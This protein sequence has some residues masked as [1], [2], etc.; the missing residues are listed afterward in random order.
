MHITQEVLECLG[1]E[2][3]VEQGNGK[4]RDYY[5][6][7]NNIKTYLIVDDGDRRPK[8]QYNVQTGSATGQLKCDATCQNQNFF[9]HLT[10]STDPL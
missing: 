3:K 1:N 2:F 10:F 5:L 9:C 8:V 6:R 7:N 4:D